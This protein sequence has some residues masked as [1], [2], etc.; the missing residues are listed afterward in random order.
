[1]KRSCAELRD[2]LV[3]YVISRFGVCCVKSSPFFILPRA[4]KYDYSLRHCQEGQSRVDKVPV[5][6]W[7]KAREA[8]GQNA[9]VAKRM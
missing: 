2:T 1:M 6:V 7:Q 8:S 9:R 5:S 4:N 3:F